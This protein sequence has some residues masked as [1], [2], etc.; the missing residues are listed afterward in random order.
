MLLA[1][2]GVGFL[3]TRTNDINCGSAFV[4]S[5]VD[6][7]V[8]LSGTPAA[9]DVTRTVIRADCAQL[10]SR[11]RLIVATLVA[12]GVAALWWSRQRTRRR[13]QRWNRT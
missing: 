6:G 7:G 5:P 2:L 4:A 12:L 13:T 10:V 8:L 3:D 9:D 11:Q 1:G